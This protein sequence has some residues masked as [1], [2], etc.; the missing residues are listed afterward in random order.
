MTDPSHRPYDGLAGLYAIGGLNRLDRDRFEQHLETCTTCVAAVTELL[1]VARGLSQ[2]APRQEP[3]ARLR[4]RIFGTGQAPA[5]RQQRAARA[6]KSTTGGRIAP[7]YRVIVVACLI[8][9]G[10]LGWYA[11]HEATRARQFRESLDASALRIQVADL[12]AATSRQAAEEL[13]ASAQ[14]LA[15]PDVTS[16]RLQGQPAAPGAAGRAFLSGTQGG[17]LAA[18]N[19]PPLPPGQVYQVWLVVPPN[20]IGVGFARVD[21]AGR[22][23]ATLD[24][25][26]DAGAAIAIAVTLEPEGGVAEPRGDVY[27][28]GRTDS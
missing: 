27:L 1:P 2:A 6:A 11:A 17:V 21:G 13:R 19:V 23:F 18:S 7:V 26:D 24:P 28:L 16:I 4:R 8:V 9:A 15:A 3:P 12:D 20:P 10:A 5:P 22:I 14:V 25:S